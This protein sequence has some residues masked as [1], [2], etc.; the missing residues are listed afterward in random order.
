MSLLDQAK[1]FRLSPEI[2]LEQFS[3]TN[4]DLND[5]LKNDAIPFQQELLGVTYLFTLKEKPHDILSFFTISNDGLKLDPVS[6][7]TQKKIKKKF[8]RVKHRMDYPSVKIGR[9]GVDKKYDGSGLGSDLLDFIKDWFIDGQ[10][11]TGCRFILVD[12]YNI[13]RVLSFFQKNKFEFLMDEEREAKYSK[14]KVSE[15]KTRLMF[16]DL[17]NL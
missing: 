4:D 16:F 10:N 6:N 8:P 11:K 17:K 2:N 1:L 9:L 12:A 14:K 5:F 7:S 15:L 13:P 3:C